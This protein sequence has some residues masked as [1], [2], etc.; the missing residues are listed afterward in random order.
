MKT[1]VI[2]LIL[3]A[4]VAYGFAVFLHYRACEKKAQEPKDYAK[5]TDR[6]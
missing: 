3:F 6:Q 4:L 1:I 5:Q 2:D